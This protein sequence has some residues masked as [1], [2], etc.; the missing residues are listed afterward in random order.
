TPD[1]R[2]KVL[3][4]GLAKSFEP[5]GSNITLSNSPTLSIAGTQQGVILGTAAYMSPEQARGKAVDKRADVWAFGV[6]FYEM[7]TGRPAFQGDDLSEILAA[8]IKEQPRWEGI[9]PNARRLLEK[10]LEK[11]PR[12]RLR[13]IGDAWILLD[14]D[15]GNVAPATKHA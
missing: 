5:E 4:F 12:R 9:P 10:C 14:D 15:T 1:G 3:D 13:D 8:V 6:V 11:D 2:V 7:L